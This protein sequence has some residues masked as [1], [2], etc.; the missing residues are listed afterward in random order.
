MSR[1]VYRRGRD[2]ISPISAQNSSSELL[3]ADETFIGVSDD[4]ND[5]SS[6]CISVYSDCASAANGLVLQ[7]SNDDENWTDLAK[8][9]VPPATLSTHEVNLNARY[10][11]L[12]YTNSNASQSLFIL[13]AMYHDRPAALFSD[14]SG[15]Y[16]PVRITNGS[17]FNDG[18]AEAARQDR[19]IELLEHL[20][21]DQRITNYH[22]HLL[23]DEDVCGDEFDIEEN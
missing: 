15:N 7:T 1:R 22:L 19:I 16:V 12:R 4:I 10:F 5:L 11:R 17:E 23:T 3:G 14:E 21:I 6:V 20:V 2:G 18:T 13:Q 9:T 8:F